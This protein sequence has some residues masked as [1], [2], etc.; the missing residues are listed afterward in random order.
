MEA[1]LANAPPDPALRQMRIKL[2]KPRDLGSILLL[3]DGAQF[4]RARD[5]SG[6][7]P[8]HRLVFLCF[9]ETKVKRIERRGAILESV[10][11]CS[12]GGV[13]PHPSY[14]LLQYLV[15]RARSHGLQSSERI[16]GCRR[17]HLDARG[18]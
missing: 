15:L 4:W 10:L 5:P 6:R 16:A 12:L 8:R 2:R 18:L 1:D 17:K 7:E 9:M 11:Q 13:F 14:H 3:L